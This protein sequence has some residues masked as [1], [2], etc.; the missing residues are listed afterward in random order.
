MKGGRKGGEGRGE[1][2]RGGA[3]APQGHS[4]SYGPVVTDS[5]GRGVSR[6]TAD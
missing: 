3:K 2:R 6:Q 5:R 4:S 1:D